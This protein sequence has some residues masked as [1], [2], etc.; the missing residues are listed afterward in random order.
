MVSVL[1]PVHILEQEVPVL[2]VLCFY[3]VLSGAGF[4]WG[5]LCKFESKTKGLAVIRA[6]DRGFMVQ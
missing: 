3:R 2:L 6:I 4:T 1:W 5:K